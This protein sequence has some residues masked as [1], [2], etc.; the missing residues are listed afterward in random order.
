MAWFD[1]LPYCRWLRSYGHCSCC[2]HGL[3]RGHAANEE[4]I[5]SASSNRVHD[6]A[7][8]CSLHNSLI[9]TWWMWFFVN[10][11]SYSRGCNR[12][13]CRLIPA[14]T[15]L[16]FIFS[17]IYSMDRG[18]VVSPW[19]GSWTWKSWSWS[20]SWKSGCWTGEMNGCLKN[21]WSGCLVSLTP[22]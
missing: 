4:T 21:C 1:D 11:I 3:W 12:N 9:I 22:C 19:T 8:S 5:H 13:I 7:V 16:F 14:H 20:W 10:F 6:V 17:S 18:E 2:W 15:F